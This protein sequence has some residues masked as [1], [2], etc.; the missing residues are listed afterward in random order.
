MKNVLI[1][2]FLVVLTSHLMSA[3][4]E[5]SPELSW[6]ESFEKAQKKAKNQEKKLLVFFTGSDWCG[7]CKLLV[8]DFFESERFIE[9]AKKDLVLYEADFPRDK[10]L[11][12]PS[13]ITT[14]KKLS[15]KYNVYS[16]PTV[17]VFD[18][19]GKEIARRKSY[20]L[21]RDTSYYFDF[22]S[23]AIQ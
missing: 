11:V 17:I 18:S 13:Q 16:Y 15:S 2:F 8:E 23:E 20:N 1:S 4:G 19:A 5:F 9:I 6:N 14:N 22:L 10:E 12:S 3:Q 21:L 7:P